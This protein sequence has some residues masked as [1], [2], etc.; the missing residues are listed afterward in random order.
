MAHQEIDRLRWVED[1]HLMPEHELDDEIHAQEDALNT[2]MNG[3]DDTVQRYQ[4]LEEE[5][6]RKEAMLDN[7]DR[8]KIPYEL[9]QMVAPSVRL[10]IHKALQ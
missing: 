9:R 7:R 2:L 3:H 10:I 6:K 5:R 4:D 8:P 1:I